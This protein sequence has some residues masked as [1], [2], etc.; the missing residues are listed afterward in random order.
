MKKKKHKLVHL[1][2]I[3]EPILELLSLMVTVEAQLS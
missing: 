2:A 1:L 3:I